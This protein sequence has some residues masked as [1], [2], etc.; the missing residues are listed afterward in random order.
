MN[1]PFVIAIDGPAASGK[2]SLARA[3]ADKLG[4]AH[5]DTGSLYR[6]VA[7]DVIAAGESADDEAAAI[8]V[9]ENLKNTLESASLADPALK[10][11]E[12]GIGASKVSAIPAVR[13]ALH[14]Y[15][16]GFAQNPP[17]NAPGAVLDG[18]DIG[19]IICPDAPLKLYITASA[20]I[21][22]ERRLKELLSRSIS[23][24]YEAVLEEMIARDARDSGRSFRPMKPADDAVQIDTSD[25]DAEA[26]LEKALAL[27]RQRRG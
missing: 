2:G 9:A 22:A 4:F 21:R 20:E 26:V 6:K 12:M 10:S 1:T 15:Q 7:F 24:T 18:R 13:Q 14:D 5:L 8:R 27:V 11:D 17:H 16:V 25:L 23:S 19:T 3:L